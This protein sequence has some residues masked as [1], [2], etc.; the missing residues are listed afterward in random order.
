MGKNSIRFIWVRKKK[1]KLGD[2]KEA[3]LRRRL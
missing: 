1:I 2:V 3:V